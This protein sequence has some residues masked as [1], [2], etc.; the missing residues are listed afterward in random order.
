MGN[1][2][3]KEPMHIREP[4]LVRREDQGKNNLHDKRNDTEPQLPERKSATQI[5]RISNHGGLPPEKWMQPQSGKSN[6]TTPKR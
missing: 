1:F 6:V 4:E 3:G 2:E 5:P